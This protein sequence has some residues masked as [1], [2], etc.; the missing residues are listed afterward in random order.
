[1]DALIARWPKLAGALPRVDLKVRETPLERWDVGGVALQVKR[2]DLS[3]PTFGGNKARALELLLA[4][5]RRGDVLLTVGSSGSTHALAVALFGEQ[6]GARTRVFTWPQEEH[7]VSRATGERLRMVAQVTASR[8]PA[9]AMLRALLFRLMAQVRWIPA[10]GSTALGALGHANAAVELA[11]QLARASAPAPDTLVVPLGS[12]GT[13]AGLLVGLALAGLP[14]RVIGV[15]VVPRV[16]ANRRR[17]MRLARAAGAR[18]AELAG[19]GDG[20][21]A[22][23]AGA[24]TSGGW[25][26]AR[27]YL[28]REG[29]RRCA[30]T[31]ADVARRARTL[32]AHLRRPM[33]RHARLSIAGAP[34]NFAGSLTPSPPHTMP[35]SAP[36]P[37]T[38]APTEIS[39]AEQ[40]ASARVGAVLFRHRGWLP[41]P[42][43]LVPLLA[44]GTMQ[45][46][47]WIIGVVLIV[48]GE[49]IRLAGVAAAGT[50]TRRRSRTVQRLVT[51]GIFAWMRNP[52]YVGNFLIW[53]GF[54]VISGVFWFIPV[55]IL[56]FAIEYTL[57]VRYEEGVLESIFGDYRYSGSRPANR[58]NTVTIPGFGELNGG[59]AYRLN[60]ASVRL[61]ALNLLDKQAIQTMAQRTGEDIL[62]VNPDGTAVSL[63]STGANAGTTSTSRFT[64]GLGIMPPTIQ[65]SVAYD[66]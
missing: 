25:P 21:V 29:A 33:A 54:I 30:G 16:V 5:V 28:Q 42:F 11:D 50:V 43:L 8:T 39:A 31:G 26:V 52:L 49:A 61:Q 38:S 3:S 57:I 4:G 41:V 59:I 65:L 55:A 44:R 12:G 46:R 10:G 40:R 22:R 17:V 27:G 45:P 34:A 53:L 19:V 36:P 13:A 37:P 35:S 51:Y 15:R 14:T 18:F 56:L 48:L 20:C 9:T 66:F 63:V 7:A 47:N 6:L 32:L 1:M 60:R 23:G 24:R 64:T 58:P 2:D 62:S